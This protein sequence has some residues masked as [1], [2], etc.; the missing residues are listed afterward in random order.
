ME[1]INRSGYFN[2]AYSLEHRW[3]LENTPE[4]LANAFFTY[5]PFLSLDPEI[6]QQLARQVKELYRDLPE[7]IETTVVTTVIIA[8]KIQ[9]GEK[10]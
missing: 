3:V 1:A 2:L 5:S 4:S 6:Q 8:R 10:R 7:I 9:F